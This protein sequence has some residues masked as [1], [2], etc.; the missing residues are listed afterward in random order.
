M[1]N[2]TGFYIGAQ[3]GYAWGDNST[4]EFVIAA[5]VPTGFIQGFNADG[6]VGGGQ[7]HGLPN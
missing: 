2:W 1:Y 7:R 4:R 5:G 6:F 3:V